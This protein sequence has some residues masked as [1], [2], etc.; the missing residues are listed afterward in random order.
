MPLFKPT[1]L[2]LAILVLGV[3]AQGQICDLDFSLGPDA[4][5]NC[6][7]ASTLTAPP[8][9]TYLW[10]TAETTQSIEVDVSGTYSCTISETQQTIVL[11]GDFS[12][13]TNDFAT[14]YAP[15]SGGAWG[16]LSN[17]GQY[18]IA[19]NPADVHNNF[20]S[21]FDHNVGD[22][23]GS[24]LIVNGAALP[25]FRVWYQ[26][27]AVTPNTDYEFSYW[28]TSV[29]GDTPAELNFTVDGVELGNTF[30]LSTTTCDWQYYSTTWN[31]GLNVSVEIAIV[32]QSTSE[33]GNDFA[34]DDIG[35]SPVCFFTDEIEILIPITP[36]VTV[37]PDLIICAGE[38]AVLNATSTIPGSTY[39]WQPGDLTG[40][41]I[42]VTP[43]A[44]TEYTVFTTSPQ[45][46]DS[47]SES[48][49]VSVIDPGNYDLNVPANYSTCADIP[50]QLNYQGTD[51]GTFS[52]QPATGL[53]N[54]S[55]ANPT[56]TVSSNTN[57][58]VTFTNACG[59]TQIANTTVL[60]NEISFSLGP[61]L[62]LCEGETETVILTEGPEY[63]WQDGSSGNQ[64][65]FSESGIYMVTGVE[66]NCTYSETIVVNVIDNPDIEIT[67]T[68]EICPGE[69][70]SLSATAGNY[71]YEWNDGE[72]GNT[73][74]I[75]T[76]GIYTVDVIDL[77]SG[78]MG[79]AAVQ[80]TTL[81]L[82][83]VTLG[84]TLDLCKG[85]TKTILALSDNNSDLMWDD[86]TAGGNYDISSEGV[87]S[88]TATTVCGTRT[89]SIE[90]TEVNCEQTLFIP[91]SFTPNGDGIND[92]FKAVG[93]GII[94][95]DFKIY[96]RWGVLQFST[97][98]IEEGWNGSFNN[99]GY[100]VDN[101]ACAY[102]VNV[103]YLD[104]SA[105]T[106]TGMVNVI[107]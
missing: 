57:Y 56:A 97:N 52:W 73:I 67:G 5:L 14:D 17:A 15:G 64:Y 71:S 6:E 69:P 70:G 35:F 90:V 96:N 55:I 37:S 34:I 63:T 19:A 93:Q 7:E 72:D 81:P 88:V 31:S 22:A 23:T 29:V 86:G 41:T 98:D 76:G 42:S 85:S 66:N 20:V 8:G 62:T 12:D 68:M 80:V 24:M 30:S 50:I 2:F 107:R 1:I 9:Y 26:T 11:N 103:E 83:K 99:N 16:L 91:N 51:Q 87:Y 49:A 94:S 3:S 104:G 48:I 10:N 4:T 45:N 53:D 25:N 89:K 13:G 95:F 32:N 54:P 27:V 47:E 36:E 43:S 40:A 84:E 92:I 28:A 65:T 79:S 102:I 106:Y 100:Y 38:N 105:E 46:C 74:E 61:D 44:D 78:C 75:S 77:Q 101:T 82:P 60:A 59:Q 39:T 18:A 21:C 58:T 33:S